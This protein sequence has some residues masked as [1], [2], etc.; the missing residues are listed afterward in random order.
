MSSCVSTTVNVKYQDVLGRRKVVKT[1][2][3]ELKDFVSG[4][5]NFDNTVEGTSVWTNDELFYQL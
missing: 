2:A 5:N 4:T 1:I 3:L